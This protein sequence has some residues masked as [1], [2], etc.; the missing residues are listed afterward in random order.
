M[1]EES[2]QLMLFDETYKF[3]LLH[4]FHFDATEPTNVIFYILTNRLYYPL[5]SAAKYIFQ[6]IW[7][8]K[9]EF[10]EIIYK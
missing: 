4:N 9:V 5:V 10:M 3:I 8:E 7:S 2:L 6:L 1:N